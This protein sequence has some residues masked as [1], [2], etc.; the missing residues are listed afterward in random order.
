MKSI[1]K[2][3]FHLIEGKEEP[4][5][6]IILELPLNEQ[7]F[8]RDL[9]NITGKMLL[10]GYQC[11]HSDNLDYLFIPNSYFPQ[12]LRMDIEGDSIVYLCLRKFTQENLPRSVHNLKCLRKI[13]L[14]NNQILTL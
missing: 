7:K 13:W 6:S 14:A 3:I 12:T 1:D 5:C 8:L 10:P 9:E 4:D 11:Q 2:Q